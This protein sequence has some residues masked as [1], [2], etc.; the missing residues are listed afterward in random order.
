[1]SLS[2]KNLNK[3][4]NKAQVLSDVNLEVETG[5]FLVLLGP[6]G[7]GKSTLLNCV[8]GLENVDHGGE[9]HIHNREVT[10]LAPKDRNIAM[11]F[12]SYA[13]YPTMKVSQNITFGLK[14]RG[15]PRNEIE[16]ALNKT[17][18]L[19]QIRDLLDRKPASLSGGQRQRVAM[20]R[21]LVHKPDIFL[22]DEPM[23]N[24]DA[25]LRTEMRVELK[26]LHRE[27]NAT[28][29]FVTHDQIEA[30]S[31]ASKIA[32]LHQGCLQQVGTPDEIYQTPKNRFV[33]EFIGTPRMNFIP[34][35]LEI[36]NG[37]Y[38]VST[39]SVRFPVGHYTFC[40]DPDPGSLVCMGIRP[41]NLF[42]HEP[43]PKPKHS[44]SFEVKVNNVENLGPDLSV[45]SLFG[46]HQL[47]LKIPNSGQ[48]PK[49]GDTIKVWVDLSGC[50]IFYSEQGARL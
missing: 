22:L 11:V 29:V 32:V 36:F 3:S 28:I 14:C 49:Y 40:N 6:S 43:K 34:G 1:M 38:F 10:H 15:V 31:L 39:E 4:F 47:T 17:A 2:I 19:L 13:L 37:E 7:C 16:N 18:D 33:A 35:E 45:F 41:E 8:A 20:G 24:L 44:V 27:L 42:I 30:M 9:I 12:Q 26:N 46:K 5:E 48:K 25:K 21:A 50:S 23:S